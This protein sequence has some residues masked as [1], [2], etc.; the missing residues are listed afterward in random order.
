LLLLALLFGFNSFAAKVSVSLLRFD[1]QWSHFESEF[2]EF[3]LLRKARCILQLI[4]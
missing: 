3:Y 4:F 2:A 1:W